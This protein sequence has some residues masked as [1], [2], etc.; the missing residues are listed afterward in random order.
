MSRT[1]RPK[2]PHSSE[3]FYLEASSMSG[4]ISPS[5]ITAKRPT[6]NRWLRRWRNGDGAACQPL[7]L[8]VPDPTF[9]RFTDLSDELQVHIIAFIADAPYEDLSNGD[10]SSTLT[11]TL[12]LVSR[13]F[14]EMANSNALWH[15]ALRRVI[16]S[17]ET[18]RRAAAA[19]S[20]WNEYHATSSS[21]GTSIN[22]KSLYRDIFETNV[23][24]TGPV[25]IMPMPDDQ[26]SPVYDLFIFERRYLFMIDCLLRQ[27]QEWVDRGSVGSPPPMLFMHAHQGHTQQRNALLVDMVNCVELPNGTYAVTLQLESLLRIER[28][29]VVPNT[30]NLY[31]ALGRRTKY[32]LQS[33]SEDNSIS[34]HPPFVHRL[35]R[36][37]RG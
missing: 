35:G 23:A 7:A 26:V 10:K 28:S 21:T 22:F 36:Q 29:W 37:Y 30:G 25:F 27:H 3:A 4:T 1:A 12:P 9:F 20:L 19:S 32:V 2:L 24:F 6:P 8:A 13:K 14:C 34:S 31:Y 5:S 15:V 33:P 17:D 18:W 11:D 16:Q